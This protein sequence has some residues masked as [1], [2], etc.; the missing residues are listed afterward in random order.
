MIRVWGS[1]KAQGS[2]ILKKH[3]VHVRQHPI[4]K[5][6][7]PKP[8]LR[9]CLRVSHYQNIH[10]QN[11]TKFMFKS[12]PLLDHPSPRHKNICVTSASKHQKNCARWDKVYVL[13]RNPDAKTPCGMGQNACHKQL[14]IARTQKTARLPALCFVCYTLFDL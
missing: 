1:P 14:L 2:P 5:A 6:S 4:T 3:C 8:Y 10:A 11:T 7:L 13:P 12:I 9:S